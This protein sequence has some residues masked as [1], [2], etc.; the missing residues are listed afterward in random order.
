MTTLQDNQF[1]SFNV[2]GC[3][4][5][6]PL[7]RLSHLQDS[8]LFKDT[9]SDQ[10]PRWFI[11]RDGCTFRHVHYYL[12]TGKLATTCVSELNILCEL[13]ASLRLTS[14]LQALENLQ[15]G[16]HFLRARAVDVQVTERATLNYWKT[17]ICNTRQPEPVASPVSSVH[18][19]VP[20]GLV[21]TPLVDGDEEVLYCFIPMETVRLYPA[22]VTADN[23]LWL[24]DDLAIIECD[25]P[26]FRFI[27][28]YLRT[29][30]I[31]LPEEFSE[32]GR[33]NQEATET[34]MTDF[35]EALQK[36]HDLIGDGGLFPEGCTQMR[37]QRMT[38]QPLYVMTFDL[39]VRY[40]DS[41][42]GQ[43]CVNS[44]M[45]SSRLHIT[46]NGVVFQHVEN[47]LGTSRLPLTERQCDLQ[48]LCQYLDR[49]DGAYHAFRE[50]LW[51]FLWR[52]RTSGGSSTNGLWSAS[53]TT[54]TIY[55]VVKVYVG[56]HWYATYFRTLLKH[57]ELLSNPRKSSWIAYGQSLHIVADGSM[58]RHVLNF[59]RCGRLLLPSGFSEWRLL[60]H[61]VEEFHIPALTRALEDCLDY[62]AW[63]S[64]EHAISLQ[65]PHSAQSQLVHNPDY[66]GFLGFGFGEESMDVSASSTD[67]VKSPE[68]SFSGGE[69]SCSSEEP[70]RALV[71]TVDEVW[72][73]QHPPP[74]PLNTEVKSIVKTTLESS[75]QMCHLS[76]PTLDTTGKLPSSSAVENKISDTSRT[77]KPSRPLERLKQKLDNATK[78]FQPS[79][80]S[81]WQKPVVSRCFFHPSGPPGGLIKRRTSG[82]VSDISAFLPWM[83]Q[84]EE[85]PLQRLAQLVNTFQ[86]EPNKQPSTDVSS[87]TPPR[88][89]LLVSVLPSRLTSPGLPS[90][91]P[92]AGSEGESSNTTGSGVHQIHWRGP[93]LKGCLF[94]VHGCALPVRGCVLRVDHPPVLGRG[95]PGGYFTHSHIYTASPQHTGYHV[96]EDQN[97]K[98]H[99]KNVAFAW[100]NM[101]W[102]EMVYGRQCHSFLAGLILDS[103]RLQDP[104]DRTHNIASLVYCL[105]TGQM[106]TE[107]FVSELVRTLC[108]DR[109]QRSREQRLLQWLEFSLPL[110]QRY[111]EC[112][113]Q[114]DRAPCHKASLFPQDKTTD[115]QCAAHPDAGQQ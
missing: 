78:F 53:V 69:K 39:L 108:C 112:L 80:S 81:R 67:D 65:P 102:E 60:C 26:L 107:V 13:T 92:G 17:R 85:A 24:C 37:Q 83:I 6:I 110:A 79:P 15:S 20:L 72:L 56:T 33:L 101:S 8:L 48:G 43:L 29:G 16:K 111:T 114:L 109:Q 103:L 82:G 98:V 21:G 45:G 47:W 70:E 19:A 91:A 96:H 74:A 51:E 63:C 27:A 25:S 5:S 113:E 35:I 106:K 40:Q 18:D 61:E 64:K 97:V 94:P 32:Y 77:R 4:F 86:R 50:A 11:D 1:L 30:K 99:P 68:D 14:L 58:F 7:N 10:N 90:G 76:V 31:L 42:L 73:C 54:L 36:L 49:Q 46:G 28:N 95:T 66:N 59:L 115:S 104:E 38:P 105:W 41:A 87:C 34:G 89:P 23:L 57:P 93:A 55:K 12:Q 52:T 88:D 71:I 22:L 100:F 75:S 9:S 62:R 3:S 2:G 84:R 44:N